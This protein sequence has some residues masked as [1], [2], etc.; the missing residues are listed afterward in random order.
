MGIFTRFTMRSLAKNRT[1][2][3]VSIIGVALSCALITAV[4]T[5]V[6]SLSNMLIER[7]AADEGWWY[8]EAAGITA[9]DLERLETDPEVTDLLTITDLGTVSL[10][11]DNSDLFGK[12]L[13]VKTWPDVRGEDEPLI[14][15]PEIVSGRAPEAPG[16]ILPPPL[17][18]ERR[19]RA[20][21]PLDRERRRHRGGQ[22]RHPR[23]GHAHR[24]EP[25]GR[26]ERHGNGDTRRLHR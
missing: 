16:E 25:V 5:S 3:V 9:D 4:L 11:E 6:V 18:A 26:R 19:A 22:Q 10:G 14:S 2:T 7:T 15:T 8:A 13:Y 21:R 24:H 23:P 17:P 20:L 12:Y 1:R